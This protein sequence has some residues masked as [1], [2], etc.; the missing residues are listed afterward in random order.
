MAK[1]VVLTC[2]HCGNKTLMKLLNQYEKVTMHELDY[3]EE[4]VYHDIFEVFECPVCSGFHLYH[5]HWNT[6]DAYYEDYDVY[7]YGT[8]LYPQMEKVNLNG[9]PKIIRK[10]YESALNVKNIDNTVCA[11]A[12][13]R[14]LEMVCKDQGAVNG[15]LHQKLNQLQQK[16]ILPPLMGD[17]SKVIKDFGNMVLMVTK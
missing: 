9:L 8:V 6:E 12:L 15:K 10:A 11:I 2:P 5:T 17:I 3:N 1:D 7:E 16:G 4:A 14:T 13:R